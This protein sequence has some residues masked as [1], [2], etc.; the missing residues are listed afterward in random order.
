LF[1]DGK[2]AKETSRVAKAID[3]VGGALHQG[4]KIGEKVG[5]VLGP[6]APFVKGAAGAA[7]EGAKKLGPIGTALEVGGVAQ[8]VAEGHYAEA[9]SDVGRMVFTKAAAAGAAMVCSESGPGAAIAAVGANHYAGK[10]WDGVADG[11][12]TWKSTGQ[13]LESMGEKFIRLG[14]SPNLT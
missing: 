10:L 6:A 14:D 7:V 5:E 3:E 11:S 1:E 13:A 9:G 8:A 2:H 12:I 4:V